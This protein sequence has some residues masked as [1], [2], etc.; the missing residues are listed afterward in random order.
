MGLLAEVGSVYFAV[1]GFNGLHAGFGV[2]ELVYG[3]PSGSGCGAFF[4]EFLM[5]GNDGVEYIE[6][7][8]A[9]GIGGAHDRRDIVRVVYVFE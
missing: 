3:K 2:G 5:W 7:L 6:L 4:P 8:Y 9:H 1:S